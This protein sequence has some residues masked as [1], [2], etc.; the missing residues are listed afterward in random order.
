M[1]LQEEIEEFRDPVYGMVSNRPNPYPETWDNPAMFTAIYLEMIQEPPTQRISR[2]VEEALS[3]WSR[4][5]SGSGGP[6]S[7]DELIGWGM[8]RP[9]LIP[10]ILDE[11][12]LLYYRFIDVRPFLKMRMGQNIGLASQIVWAGSTMVNAWPPRPVTT[13]K[14]QKWLTL[15]V[16]KQRDYKICNG[17][18]AYWQE[19]SE[20]KYPGG[21]A[22]LFSVYFPGHPMAKYAQKS[23]NL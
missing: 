2:F 7:Q 23:F 12:P 14:P 11:M 19:S 4:W 13:W 20:Q 18:I 16:V 17:S 6:P 1:S 9:D 15:R 22:D 21:L 10:E 8:L 3:S 5:P